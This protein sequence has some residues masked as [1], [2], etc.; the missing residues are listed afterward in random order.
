M[1]LHKI[2]KTLLF[3][4]AGSIVLAHVVLAYFSFPQ[5]DTFAMA[6]GI[7]SVGILPTVATVYF[8]WIGRW[9]AYFIMGVFDSPSLFPA[10]LHWA[11]IANIL[12]FV[13]TLAMVLHLGLRCK[14]S[15]ARVLPI[16]DV[17]I[18]LL[19]LPLSIMKESFY[20][21]D[22]IACYVVP[23]WLVFMLYGLLHYRG[24]SVVAD[25]AIKLAAFLM[26]SFNETLGI[27]LIGLMMCAVFH[28]W[29]FSLAIPPIIRRLF[30]PICVGWAFMTFAP[31]NFARLFWYNTTQYGD[32]NMLD[33]IGAN[34]HYSFGQLGAFTGSMLAYGILRAALF[35]SVATDMRAVK[36]YGWWLFPVIL[37]CAIASVFPAV[38]SY[39][40]T[41][42]IGGRIFF[43]AAI[44]IMFASFLAGEQ[45]HDYLR[46]KISKVCLAGLAIALSLNL[47]RGADNLLTAWAV[48]PSQQQQIFRQMDAMEK[49]G[50]NGLEGI[51]LGNYVF[52]DNVL[53]YKSIAT[54]ESDANYWINRTIAQYYGLKWMR[55]QPLAEPP[56]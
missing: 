39:M 14:G 44:A 50:T 55:T 20:W 17:A 21:I 19:A 7:R 2:F 48:A 52:P 51:V 45:I 54:D 40:G 5:A 29:Y 23:V 6:D 53:V 32:R 35:P 38:Y 1:S 34:F 22:T 12:I 26:A 41:Y 31:G 27:F 43:A 15:M 33:M 16:L 11:V 28:S 18:I 47:A 3:F 37:A 25:F 56:K 8:T 24:R 49:A 4:V 36:R 9:T 42:D 13:V 10:Y 30:A 46:G